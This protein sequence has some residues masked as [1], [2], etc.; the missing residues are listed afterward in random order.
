MKSKFIIL[1]SF[2]AITQAMQAQNI[3]VDTSNA[4]QLY[5][6]AHQLITIKDSLPKT[7]LL[8]EKAKTLYNSYPQ[9]SSKIKIDALLS[10]VYFQNKLKQKA[11][12]LAHQVIQDGEKTLLLHQRKSLGFAYLT[13]CLYYRESDVKQ[14]LDYGKKALAVSSPTQDIYFSIVTPLAYGYSNN[15]D[16]QSL[17]A[18]VQQVDSIIENAEN[19]KLKKFKYIVYEGQMRYF[20]AIRNFESA[21]IYG[22]KLIRELEKEERISMAATL[23][24]VGQYYFRLGKPKEALNYSI[25]A[26]EAYK[27]KKSP[28]YGA[29]LGNLGIAYVANQQFEKAIATFEQAIKLME[30]D[31]QGNLSNIIF[32]FA[33]I[34]T[35]YN[36][37]GHPEKGV[38]A[39]EKGLQYG[40]NNPYYIYNLG[41][42]AIEIQQLEKGLK[43][44][45]KTLISITKIFDN[46]NI[47]SNPSPYE[48]YTSFRLAGGLLLNK[49]LTQIKIGRRDNDYKF[50]KAGIATLDLAVN[51]YNDLE[52]KAKGFEQSKFI[53]NQATLNALN[54]KAGALYD[55]YLLDN[56]EAILEDLFKAFEQR[57]AMQLI[58][59]LS[60]SPLPDALYQEEKQLVTAIQLHGQ[61]LDLAKVKKMPKDSI[62]FFQEKLFRANNKMKS[63]L[64]KI[65][66]DY[67]KNETNSSINYA[68]IQSIQSQLDDNT[69]VISYNDASSAGYYISTISHNTS[70]VFRLE[71]PIDYS[72]V[73][74]LNQLIQDPFAFQRAIRE[75]FIQVSHELYNVLIQPIEKELANKS[76]LMI[77]PESKLFNLP[78]E[79]LLSSNTTSP[80]SDLNYLIK[81][82]DINYHYSA[83]AYLKLQSKPS[84]QDNSLLAFAPVFEKGEQMSDATRSLDFMVDSLY[85]SINNN[86]F[87]ALPNTKR[88][89]KTIAKMLRKKG[90]KKV[91]L[92]KNASKTN[93]SKAFMQSS[94]Q[95]I[96]I[97]T[98]G[99][100]NFKNPKLSALA[101]YSSGNDMDNLFYTNEI[102][103]ADIQADLVVL[104]SCE[105]GI[106]QLI[107]G[108]GLIAL[109]RS[110]F[111]SGAKNVL[112][113]LWKVN[114]RL[115]SEFMIEFYKNYLEGQTY[116]NALRNTK[117]KMLENPEAALP[118]NWAA[119]I[120]MGE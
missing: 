51:V 55:L 110:F 67:P 53:M 43:L 78:F 33:N 76:K 85:R 83:T 109:N 119:F 28:K 25:R 37:L 101:C 111:Y 32:C 7:Q 21:V 38:S 36:D 118:K 27:D 69:L 114:D 16:Y 4:T 17:N 22:E 34:G 116:T 112:F 73:E 74:R 115:S 30:Q 3:I 80:Y 40:Q 20:A 60:P 90:K 13:M 89:V 71:K 57:K 63:F 105:S 77:I 23:T 52:A 56:D 46:D 82:F 12:E 42:L 61:Q 2:L 10:F 49:G 72:K 58:E 24:N 1:I 29:Y 106:G 120:L 9:S 15:S 19:Q 31:P 98:H 50:L 14:S 99:L 5:E 11:Y 107:H 97:A 26:S 59:T 84:I 64:D 45:H 96:H 54:Y 65:A 18:L 6:K 41:A 100:V 35:A 62:D 70:Q 91:L 87:V 8:L 108:E 79:I 93:L 88:E 81:S 95:F 113:S 94:Y 44:F 48:T 68:K 75:E 104:S 47:M 92:D 102:Q 86:R 103:N 66:K 39:M 117:L